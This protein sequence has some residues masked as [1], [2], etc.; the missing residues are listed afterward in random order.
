MDNKISRHPPNDIATENIQDDI[1]IVV[2]PLDRPFE[3]GDIPGPNLVRFGGQQLGLG[4]HG[5]RS[6]GPPF[7]N[8]LMGGQEAIH[9]SYRTQIVPFFQEPGI[10]L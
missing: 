9:G 3:L 1:Q 7:L 5:M 4:V 8:F 10:D 6:H 2:G